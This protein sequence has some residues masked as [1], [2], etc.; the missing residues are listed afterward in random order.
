ML[1]DTG[2]VKKD[3]D[4]YFSKVGQAISEI[5]RTGSFV[6]LSNDNPKCWP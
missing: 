3:E 2:Q 5:S 6:V 4:G 1:Y